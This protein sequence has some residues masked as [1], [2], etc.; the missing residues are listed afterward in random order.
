M[1]R[2]RGSILVQHAYSSYGQTA[3]ALK[4]ALSEKNQY[5]NIDLKKAYT[6]I[7]LAKAS[8]YKTY[9]L[10]NQPKYGF[11][12]TPIS[13]MGTL[14][15]EQVWLNTD[16]DT[17][18]ATKKSYDDKLLPVLP[19]ENSVDNKFIIIHI[20]GSHFL[21]KNRY[22][23]DYDVYTA[24]DK[25]YNIAAYDNSILYTDHIL[26]EIYERVSKYPDFKAFI[27][28]SD[29]GEDVDAGK[30]H[31]NFDTTFPMLKIPFFI[32]LSDS[33]IKERPETYQTLKQ[34]QNVF[35]TNDLLHDLLQDLMGIK[36]IHHLD[37][38]F[39]L[40]SPAYYGTPQNLKTIYG[41]KSLSEDPG[42][43]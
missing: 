8:G 1:M 37:P 29:H 35:W 42:L 26:Q 40:A 30:A 31:G 3:P 14:A 39:D 24:N 21:Y 27:Y 19:A 36:N 15:D 10:S 11:Y 20:E 38:K 16:M 17:K 33:F 28:M 13:L 2:E 9:W 5:N 23:S 41:Q 6:I 12:G 7:E 4:Y 32:K 34:H 18:E 25:N 43:K 22:P